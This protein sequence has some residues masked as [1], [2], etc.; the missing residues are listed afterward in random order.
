MPT[1][2]LVRG[3]WQ[4]G[5]CY[6]RVAA[7]LLRQAG[8]EV[9]TPTL[10]SLGERAHLLNRA[11]DLDTHVQDIVGI[12]RRRIVGRCAVW[13]FLMAAWLPG[14]PSRSR[15][16]SI[17]WCV[18]T[19]SCPRTA[20]LC[21]TICGPSNRDRCVTTP[22]RTA[23]ATRSRPFRRLLSP[24]RPRTPPGSIDVRQ[25]ATGDIRAE[26][27]KSVAGRYRSACTCLPP[28]GS[29]RPSSHSARAS[30]T[31]EAGVRQLRLRARRDDGPRSLRPLSLPPLRKARAR[32]L[33]AA[34][35]IGARP[36]C[37]FHAQC[38][39]GAR[40]PYLGAGALAPRH[41]IR[42]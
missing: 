26:C 40:S 16:R 7:R 25:A 13:P 22:R 6:K 19:P 32:W 9:C 3:A 21:L 27:S 1:F 42:A 38:S 14:S 8:H 11:I 30:R 33:V 12:I 10:T 23:K 20:S 2:V 24:S 28:A 35:R 18:S 39:R 4:G 17:P 34:A 29:R 5:W 15:R 37:F 36:D 31:I 41:N